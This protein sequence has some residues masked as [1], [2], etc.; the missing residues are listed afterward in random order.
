MMTVGELIK[1]L[2]ELDL[3]MPVVSWEDSDHTRQ[4]PYQEGCEPSVVELY[5]V[6]EGP[7]YRGYDTDSIYKR[8]LPFKAV[9][10]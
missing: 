9:V 1:K 4:P 6:D 3:N 10:I 2:S 8:G 5:A 7:S